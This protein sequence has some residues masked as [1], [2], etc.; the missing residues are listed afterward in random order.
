MGVVSRSWLIE[1]MGGSAG[2]VVRVAH[3]VDLTVA[4]IDIGDQERRR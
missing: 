4:P 3:F 1:G 2:A